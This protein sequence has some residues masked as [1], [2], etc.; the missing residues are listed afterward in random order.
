M[1]YY[2]S[3]VAK[4]IKQ[5]GFYYLR[6]PVLASITFLVSLA[7]LGVVIYELVVKVDLFWLKWLY[8]LNYAR[9]IGT[10]KKNYQ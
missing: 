10:G 1:G 3:K 8:F 5:S 2:N 4:E 7:V 6:N 9:I